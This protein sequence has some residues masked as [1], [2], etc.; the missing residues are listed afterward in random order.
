MQHR[1]L[2]PGCGMD[3]D[4]DDDDDEMS[5]RSK[6][7]Q[8]FCF[9]LLKENQGKGPNQTNFQEEFIT[10][11]HVIDPVTQQRS[12]LL[13]PYVF[14]VRQDQVLQLYKLTFMKKGLAT[15]IVSLWRMRRS[16]VQCQCDPYLKCTFQIKSRSSLLAPVTHL[17]YTKVRFG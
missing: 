16:L 8:Q 14:K 12:R 5:P 2:N 15:G 7:T 3:D 4:D 11:D 9:N 1:E 17:A 13:N 10:V 6:V